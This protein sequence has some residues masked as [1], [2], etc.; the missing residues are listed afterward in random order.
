MRPTG[1]TQF[2]L[3][4]KQAYN[5]YQKIASRC[6]RLEACTMSA[7]R[8][9]WPRDRRFRIALLVVLINCLPHGAI[10]AGRHVTSRF[11]SVES[12]PMN[13]V[14][15]PAITD[16]N[17]GSE[18]LDDERPWEAEL[19]GIEAARARDRVT[20]LNRIIF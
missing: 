6:H 18:R 13:L 14:V 16:L 2:V 3:G 7:L 12:R 10:E 4:E 8:S 11:R 17:R 20:L 9:I 19:V 5:S 15:L 1:S